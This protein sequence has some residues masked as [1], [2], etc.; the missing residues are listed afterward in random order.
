MRELVETTNAIRIWRYSVRRDS[1]SLQSVRK[2]IAFGANPNADF[3]NTTVTDSRARVSRPGKDVGSVLIYAAFSG[4]PDVVRGILRYHPNLEARDREGKTAVFAAG[5][6]LS[7]DKE[8]TRV[9]CVRLLAQADAD[10]NAR[11]KAA[12]PRFRR[13]LDRCGRRALETGRKC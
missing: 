10:V 7:S 5:E 11:D 4:N 1:G 6:Y 9:H 2:L 8:G 13:S 12:T 3:S